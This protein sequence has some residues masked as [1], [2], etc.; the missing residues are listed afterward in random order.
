MKKNYFITQDTVKHISSLAK[1]PIT[2][3]EEVKLTEGFNTTLDVVNRLY[4]IKAISPKE[5][6]L[7]VTGLYNVY[8]NDE[9]DESMTLTQEQALKNA[10]RKYKGYFVVPAIFDE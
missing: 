1:I 4:K 10:K 7:S 5:T 8:R 3:K 9:I 6:Y 2:E